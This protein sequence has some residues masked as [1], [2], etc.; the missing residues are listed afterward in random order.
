M[1]LVFPLLVFTLIF[2]KFAGIC[3]YMMLNCL[4]L[5]DGAYRFGLMKGR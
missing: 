2:S 3:V 4:V 5:P 1:F